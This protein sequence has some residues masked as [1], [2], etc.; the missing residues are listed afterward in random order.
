MILYSCL[1]GEGEDNLAADLAIHLK[2]PVMAPTYYWLMQT[3]VPAR[4]RIPELKLDR[5]GHLTIDRSQF[6]LFYKKRHQKYRDRHSIAPTAM[7]ALCIADGFVPQPSRFRR[8][9]ERFRP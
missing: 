3:A 6:A 9:F 5:H 4:Q 7:G 1:T 2:R 8:L